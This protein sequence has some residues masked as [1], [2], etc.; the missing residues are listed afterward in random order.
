MYISELF[1]TLIVLLHHGDIR[2]S[3]KIKIKDKEDK[4]QYLL[5]ITISI[6]RSISLSRSILLSSVL[7]SGFDS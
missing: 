7:V 5:T 1:Y 3:T 6:S 4:Y 2:R